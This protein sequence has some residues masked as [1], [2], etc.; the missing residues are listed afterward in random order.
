VSQDPASLQDWPGSV[1][2][3]L[4]QRLVDLHLIRVLEKGPSGLHRALQARLLHQLLQHA[5]S[6]SAWWRSRLPDTPASLGLQAL[7]HL[8]IQN[9]SVLRQ[10]FAASPALPL[11]PIHGSSRPH[12]TSGTSGEPL[13]FHVTDHVARMNSHHYLADHERHGRD[14]RQV[15]ATLNTRIAP[16]PGQVQVSQ[17]AQPWL[18]EGLSHGRHAAQFSL[19][20]N[21]QWLGALAPRYFSVPPLLFQALLDEYEDGVP[22][23]RG[24][25]QVLTVGEHVPDALRAR[26]RDLLGASIRDRYSCEEAGPIAFQCPHDESRYHVAVSNVVL[27]VVDEQGQACAEGQA[28][29]VLVTGLHNWA[30]PFIRYDV[31]DRAALHPSCTCGVQLP[32]LSQ[33]LGR[34]LFL[35]R[36]PS[37]G[38]I[39]ALVR[40][41][42]WLPLAPVEQFRIVQEADLRVRVELLLAQRLT[43]EQGEAMQAMLKRVISPELT[44]ELVQ[45]EAIEPAR[46]G[47]PA[48]VIS[49]A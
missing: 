39:Y 7:M 16:H 46:A 19:R 23:P 18:G 3:Q 26:C 5:R 14:L 2:S 43:R 29:R 34:T 47:K 22:A 25:E 24:L 38:R 15:R 10:A 41:R 17:P 8:P 30:S 20:E 21:A 49:R 32:T 40:A 42:D 11:P 48:P 4:V 13:V 35:Y 12:S 31:G 6:H 9:R 33:L 44:Y 45:V 1:S 27:E 28:G 37:G 36:L